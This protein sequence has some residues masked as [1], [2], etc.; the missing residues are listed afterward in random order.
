MTDLEVALSVG[1]HD[2]GKNVRLENLPVSVQRGP[3]GC[4]PPFVDVKTKVPPQYRLLMQSGA[5]YL[6]QGFEDN[7]LGS[8]PG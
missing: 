4:T 7:V 6:S 5:S 8:F 3:S 1:V 2:R